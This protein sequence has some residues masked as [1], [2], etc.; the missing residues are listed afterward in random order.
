MGK[1]HAAP[2]AVPFYLYDAKSLRV[3]EGPLP[4]QLTF[5]IAVDPTNK[6]AVERQ[7][8][9]LPMLDVYSADAS[10]GAVKMRGRVFTP[11]PVTWRTRADV[12]VVL[13]RWKSFSRGGDELQIYDLH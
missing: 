1:K 5:G 3:E 11:R 2:L 9:D 7:K 6:D 10:S 12:L 13:K 4:G 8:V